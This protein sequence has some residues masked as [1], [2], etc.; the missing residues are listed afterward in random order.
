[1]FKPNELEAIPLPFEKFMSDLEIR[2]MQDIVRRIKINGEITRAAD[3]QIYRL[4]ELG[5][6]KE[7]ISSYI[8]E[9]L[10]LSDE[11][12]EKLYS[13]VI[14]AG[15][16]RDEKIYKATGKKFIP[17]KKNKELQQLIKATIEQTKG[18]LNNITQSLGFAK[19]VN[20]KVVFEP[21]AKV[22]QRTLDNAMMDISS[23]T[24][25]YNEVIKRT[26]SELT[27]SGLRSVDYAT[28][29]SNRVEVA[30]RRAIMTGITQLTNQ[31]NERNAAELGTEHFE[32]S[33]HATARP[34]H[35]VWQGRVYTKQ[36]LIDICGLGTGPGLMGWNCYHSYYPF[37]PG[38]SKRTYT[39]EQLDALNAAENKPKV[40]NGKEYTTYEASQRQRKLETLMRKQRQEIKLL[41]EAGANEDDIIN[42]R[43]RYRATSAQYAEF[44]KAMGLPQQRE[45]VTVD[46]LGNI[47]VGKYKNTLTNANGQ[48]IIKTKRNSLMG[49]PNSITQKTSL[50]GGIERNYYNDDGK[51]Y[52]QIS[53]NN[54]G[55]PKA[56]P[57]GKN[58]EHAHDY[59]YDKDGNLI[60]RPIRE[61]T[62][63]ERKENADI[64]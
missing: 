5:M 8:R 39:D 46:G 63:E 45:R 1:M 25:S 31:I 61:L 57:Y 52:K 23:G 9:A 64:L 16:A 42:A 36:Q 50:K 43:A 15:Y 35:Q 11:E 27:N 47:G 62:D 55:K 33:W 17:F 12:I 28:G 4:K 59:I 22:Y 24:F 14:E 49:T 6:A 26:V 41:Q 56:H 30:A 44:S 32:V 18:D 38:V 13:D 29:W 19:K 53:N 3:W 51:Q 2:I 34:E 60:D 20:G 7:E 40:Y 10:K 54:H 21:I 48:S 37:I 58:G